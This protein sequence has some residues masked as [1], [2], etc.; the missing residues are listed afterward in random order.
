MDEAIF[1]DRTCSGSLN[2]DVPPAANKVIR[3]RLCRYQGRAVGNGRYLHAD[4]QVE[5][6]ER[7]WKLLALDWRLK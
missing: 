1:R 4:E 6:A 5:E 3:G 7:L 2:G